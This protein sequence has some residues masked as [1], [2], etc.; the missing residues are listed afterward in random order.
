M[1]TNSPFIRT[2]FEQVFNEIHIYKIVTPAII[3]INNNNRDL[4]P[5]HLKIFSL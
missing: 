3:A 2:F 4:L 5:A 1:K